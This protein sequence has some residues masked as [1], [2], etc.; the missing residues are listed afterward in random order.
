M[1]KIYPFPDADICAKKHLKN[2]PPVAEEDTVVSNLRNAG[3][4]YT[5]YAY[6]TDESSGIKRKD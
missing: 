4:A 5:M 3:Y 6:L 1:S 2:R